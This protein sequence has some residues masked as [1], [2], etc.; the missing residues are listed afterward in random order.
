MASLNEPVIG[1]F[2]I[3]LFIIEAEILDADHE[4]D[5]INNL[6]AEYYTESYKIKSIRRVDGK[7]FDEIQF[8]DFNKLYERESYK[9]NNYYNHNED[10]GKEF[11]L[12]CDQ[13]V[14]KLIDETRCDLYLGENQCREIKIWHKNG[15]LK[16]KYFYNNGLIDGIFQEY[17][18]YGIL[19]CTASYMN[20]YK[21]GESINY[22]NGEIR[23]ITNYVNDNMH[24]LH[25]AYEDGDIKE[26]SIFSNDNE[27]Y[28][29]NEDE[30]NELNKNLTKLESIKQQLL[31]KYKNE[32]SL[33]IY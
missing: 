27:L 22:Y 1:Y 12:T 8:N 3:N 14:M 11:Y 25:E 10:D 33:D 31:E 26:L 19:E 21:N 30:L 23:S 6:H 5:Y 2:N 20:G 13:L 7:I 9:I 18:N 16:R 32:L 28:S 15:E 29:L 17:D 24:G 4:H